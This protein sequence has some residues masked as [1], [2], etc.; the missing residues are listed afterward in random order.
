MVFVKRSEY[1]LDTGKLEMEDVDGVCYSFDVYAVED[2]CADT[3]HE[4]S[5]LDYLL[6]YEPVK[7]V[8]L[9]LSGKLI[10]YIQQN[11][12]HLEG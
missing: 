3:M 1:D 12:I 9:L 10:E 6:Y 11:S 8:N 5:A 7:Y 2:L 4:R